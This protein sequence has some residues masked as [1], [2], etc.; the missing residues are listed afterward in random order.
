[1]EDDY[2]ELV[3][4]S[5]I[6]AANRATMREAQKKNSLALF[7]LQATL[8]ETIFPRIASCASAKAAWKALKESYEG[9][10]QVKQVRLQTLK[11]EFENLRM[12]EAEKVGDYCM[13]VKACVDKM[14]VFGEKVENEVIVK[15]VLRTLL[16]K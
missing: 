1:M 2:V 12:K 14:R 16:P 8:D 7:Y 15:K 4:W 13:R 3:D 9:N 6:P 11:M 5:A 10:T